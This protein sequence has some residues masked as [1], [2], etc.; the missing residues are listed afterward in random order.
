[1]T[2]PEFDQMNTEAT[3]DQSQIQLIDNVSEPQATPQFIEP[4][5]TVTPDATVY[6]TQE[7]LNLRY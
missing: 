1:M 6:P 2:D 4:A 7:P 3:N 5:D